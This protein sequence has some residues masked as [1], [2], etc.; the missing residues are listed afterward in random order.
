MVESGNTVNMGPGNNL[1][2]ALGV[3]KDGKIS[4]TASVPNDTEEKILDAL[5]NPKI[6]HLTFHI[7][8][9]EGRGAPANFSF[10][11]EIE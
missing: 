5:Q 10:A 1:G 6:I 11:C 9:Y 8:K 3:L 7:P 2:F 4:S